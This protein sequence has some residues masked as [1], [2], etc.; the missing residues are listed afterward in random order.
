MSSAEAFVAEIQALV[1]A[2]RAQEPRYD[3]QT[4]VDIDLLKTI[5][6]IQFER[7]IEVVDQLAGEQDE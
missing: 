6:A 4:P 1:A 2:Y 7:V 3:G 5:K